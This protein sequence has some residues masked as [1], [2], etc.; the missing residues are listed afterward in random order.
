MARK[1]ILDVDPGIDS[2]VAISLALAHPALEV[3]A[4]TAVGGNV[5]P[6]QATRNVQAIVEQLDPPRWPRLGAATT[7]RMQRFDS[8]HLFGRDGLCGAHF[9]VAELHHQRPSIKVLAD[10]L[11]NA[12]GE[13]T[14][15]AAGPLSNIA[16]ALQQQPDLAE[17]IGHLIVLGGTISGPG[18]ITPAAEFNIYCDAEA[19]RDV[20]RSQVTKTLVP[21][22][23]SSRVLFGFD[24]LSRLPEIETRTG[25][26]LQKLLPAAFRAY[27]QQ[28]GLEGIY[29]HTA[30]AVVAA[31][32]PEFFTTERLHGD[33]ETDGNLTHGVTVFDR[34]PQPENRPNMDVVVDVDEAEVADCILRTLAQA[35]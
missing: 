30:I 27:R 33:V 16:A 19:A 29:L 6:D 5:L 13:V 25:Q 18:N 7:E 24:M 26:L 28:L 14:I 10:E 31:S 35:A 12:P 2:A 15:V 23:I 21:I 34:R 17:L 9:P 20:F 32:H 22:D 1:V 11:R 3:V 4:V 8:R